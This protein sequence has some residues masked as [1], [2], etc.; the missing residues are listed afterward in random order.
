MSDFLMSLN[1]TPT[2]DTPYNRV[3]AQVLTDLEVTLPQL[4]LK[5][6]EIELEMPEYLASAAREKLAAATLEENFVESLLTN[7]LEVHREQ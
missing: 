1:Y 3:L 7:L 4:E 6:T 5:A 2:M